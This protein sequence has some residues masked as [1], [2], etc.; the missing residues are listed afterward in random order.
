[1]T[2]DDLKHIFR[3]QTTETEDYIPKDTLDYLLI[4]GNN[5][6]P[7][8]IITDKMSDLVLMLDNFVFEG[9]KDRVPYFVKL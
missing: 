9:Y 4:E 3:H 8:S 6:I 1:M 7:G 2:V 5:R